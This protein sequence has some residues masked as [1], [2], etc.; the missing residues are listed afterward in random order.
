MNTCKKRFPRA[1]A[2]LIPR[3]DAGANHHLARSLRGGI[4]HE[5][6]AALAFGL[7]FGLAGV[8][9]LLKLL[10]MLYKWRCRGELDVLA[11]FTPSEMVEHIDRGERLASGQRGRELQSGDS[12]PEAV[13]PA[14]VAVEMQAASEFRAPAGLCPGD[15]NYRE[16][17]VRG[18]L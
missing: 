1:C 5:P 2:L 11:E 10:H 4:A 13:S 3:M 16:R 17:F 7:V 6:H 14:R 9:I 15:A 12:T 18:G 8:L